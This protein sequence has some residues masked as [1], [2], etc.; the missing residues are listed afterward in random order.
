MSEQFPAPVYAETVLA[1]N[2][3]DAKRH[4]LDDLLEIHRAHTRMLAKQA[5]LTRQEERQLLAALDR[6][7]RGRIQAAPYD[8]DCEDLFYFIESL[9]EQ[10]CGRDV[11]GK[12]HT[13]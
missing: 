6:L 11:A 12:M 2:F 4:F 13:A 1:P 3:E 8:G 5:I 7:D 9:L 10:A